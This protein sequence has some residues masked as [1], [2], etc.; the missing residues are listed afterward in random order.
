M[1]PFSMKGE[2]SSCNSEPFVADKCQREVHQTEENYNSQD[3]KLQMYESTL[4]K[5]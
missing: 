2:E 4:Q 5:F 3:E 1:I